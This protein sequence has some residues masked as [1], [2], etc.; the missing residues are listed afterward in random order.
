MASPS[1]KYANSCNIYME[2]TSSPI[3]ETASHEQPLIIDHQFPYQITQP[4]HPTPATHPTHIHQR[5]PIS[6]KELPFVSRVSSDS[7]SIT[8][9]YIQKR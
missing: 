9:M 1:L 8:K 5:T 3:E 6:T 2:I 7:P 4:T